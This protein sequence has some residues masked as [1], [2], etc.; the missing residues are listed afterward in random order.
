ASINISTN[1][2]NDIKITILIT[3]ENKVILNLPLFLLKFLY[4]SS[5]SA[6]NIFLTSLELLIF[7]TF[8]LELFLIA[9]SGDILAAF[10]AGIKAD[11]NKVYYKCTYN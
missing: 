7:P 9:S 8:K 3:R 6:L 2:L 11:I 5:P 10:I 4:A 1:P